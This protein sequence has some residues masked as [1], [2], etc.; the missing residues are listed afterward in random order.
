MLIFRCTTYN[1]LFYLRLYNI[2]V[3]YNYLFYLRLYNINVLYNYLSH[4]I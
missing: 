3:L 2:N 1:T 4:M